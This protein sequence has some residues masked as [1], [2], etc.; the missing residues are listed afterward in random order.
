VP[1]ALLR[2][3]GFLS[4]HRLLQNRE[5]A[6]RAVSELKDAGFTSDEIGVTARNDHDTDTVSGN[7][8][9]DRSFWD[10]LKHFSSGESS[11]EVDYRDTS[12]GMNW[13]Q[14]RADYYYRGI[15]Q[16]ERSRVE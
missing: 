5:D 8:E 9:R 14:R 10:K 4:D 1:T 11:D 12:A 2:R 16:F 15:A 13:D 3:L 6:H 7:I